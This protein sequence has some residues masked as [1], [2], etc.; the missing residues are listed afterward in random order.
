MKHPRRDCL[1]LSGSIEYNKNPDAW[2]EKMHDSLGY[3]YHVIIP[4]AAKPP[5]NKGDKIYNDWVL[6]NFIHPDMADVARSKFFFIK[7]DKGVL[8]GAGTIS[9][10]SLATWMNKYIVA[11]LDGLEIQELPGWMCGCLTKAKFV[12]TINEAIDHFK[13]LKIEEEIEG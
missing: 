11:M 7:I 4:W 3:K 5:G 1:Y 12:K 8:K 10:L 9:E 6:Q 2:R 13:T